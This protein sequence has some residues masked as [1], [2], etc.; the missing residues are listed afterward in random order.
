VL[1]RPRL[2]WPVNGNICQVRAIFAPERINRISIALCLTYTSSRH[3]I[4]SSKK[5]VR[6]VKSAWSEGLLEEPKKVSG[7][8]CIRLCVDAYIR[9]S[10]PL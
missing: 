4:T 8:R 10:R 7:L 6:P 9:N 1:A 5:V 2:R 3:S